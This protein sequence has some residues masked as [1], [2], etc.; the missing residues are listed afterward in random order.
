MLDG[1]LFF[2]KSAKCGF[3]QGNL[4]EFFYVC[5]SLF[6]IEFDHNALCFKSHLFPFWCLLDRVCIKIRSFDE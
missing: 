4:P 6:F 3:G 5:T 2:V 1:T